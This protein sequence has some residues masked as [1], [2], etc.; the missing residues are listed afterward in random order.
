[1]SKSKDSFALE[2]LELI[3]VETATPVSKPST[4]GAKQVKP[5]VAKKATLTA[6]K[7]RK[8]EGESVPEDF[9]F[10]SFKEICQK[11]IELQANAK[12]VTV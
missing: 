6:A 12:K 1:M 10:L 7:K 11:V 3:D 8:T 2:D 9:E 4:R 5:H